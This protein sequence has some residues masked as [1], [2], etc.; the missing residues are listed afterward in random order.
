[1]YVCMYRYLHMLLT[2]TWHFQA[3][4]L[5]LMPFIKGQRT[6]SAQMDTPLEHHV[7]WGSQLPPIYIR[8]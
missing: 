6:T 2:Y 8:I 4:G 5:H 7:R 3:P 1:M